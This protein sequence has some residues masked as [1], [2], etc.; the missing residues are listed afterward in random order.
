MKSDWRTRTT[1]TIEQTAAVLGIGRASAYA[2]AGSGD[3]PVIRVGRRLLVPVGQLR[4]ML[5]EIDPTTNGAA[6]ANHGS[7]ERLV[8]DADHAPAP[9]A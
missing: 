6:A 8:D 1:L 7:E 2:A 5:G 3:L 9:Q 4:R